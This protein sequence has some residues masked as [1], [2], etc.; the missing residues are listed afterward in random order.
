MPQRGDPRPW[1]RQGT[2]PWAHTGWGEE[3]FLL[4]PVWGRT[5]GLDPGCIGAQ[6]EAEAVPGSSLGRARGVGCGSRVVS[7][8]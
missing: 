5:A 8:K 6:L 3:S 7:V 2:A 1:G 4:G